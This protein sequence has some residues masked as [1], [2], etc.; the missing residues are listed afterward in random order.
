MVKSS[1]ARA[2]AAAASAA[3]LLTLSACG[4]G[5]DSSVGFQ[6]GVYVDG[7]QSGDYVYAGDTQSVVMP[8]GASIELDA[9]EPV[10]WTLQVGST[11]YEGFD[12]SLYYQGVTITSTTL[13]SSRIALDTYSDFFLSSPVAVT[14]YAV[15][16]YDSALVATVDVLITN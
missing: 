8:V 6:V 12:T 5:G 14:L 11:Y 15:S 13:N 16:T 2:F 3:V 1:P 4:G 10:V 7:Y 9:N